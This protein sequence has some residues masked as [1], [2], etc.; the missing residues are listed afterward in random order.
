MIELQE[1][2]ESAR[3]PSIHLAVI[4]RV[5]KSLCRVEYLDGMAKV[6][7]QAQGVQS[8]R[9]L[10][11]KVDD[12]VQAQ[13]EL[14]VNGLLDIRVPICGP[15]PLQLCSEGHVLQKQCYCST[16]VILFLETCGVAKI[17]AYEWTNAPSLKRSAWFDA[18]LSES[19]GSQKQRLLAMPDAPLYHPNLVWAAATMAPPPVS[20]ERAARRFES[21][22]RTA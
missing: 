9:Y 8:A 18:L 21:L 4:V 15:F 20:F 6:S 1:A 17:V 2:D 3:R 19:R 11:Q 13:F 22:T 12:L 14:Y 5:N 16:F 10:R 7:A